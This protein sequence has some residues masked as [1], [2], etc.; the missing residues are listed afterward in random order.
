MVEKSKISKDFYEAHAM[1]GKP[2]LK[3]RK[4]LNITHGE[5]NAG[6]HYLQLQWKKTMEQLLGGILSLRLMQS[7]SASLWGSRHLKGLSKI[8]GSQ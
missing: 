3:Q 2:F 7:T 8:V 6:R 5:L 1:Y 4:S